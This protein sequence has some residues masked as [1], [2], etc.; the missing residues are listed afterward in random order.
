[1]SRKRRE[2][3]PSQ[4]KEAL[5][6]LTACTGSTV[7]AASVADATGTTCARILDHIGPLVGRRATEA[8]LA[9]SVYLSK[10][11]FPLLERVETGE[12]QDKVVRE[13]AL[14]LRAARP[15]EAMKMA[16]SVLAMFVSI[17]ADFISE[18]LALRLLREACPDPDKEQP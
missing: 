2:P 10:Q 7:D 17:L 12:A 6:L 18:S 15:D 5:R 14:C 16:I 8:L 9:R 11:K 13:L 4:L 1:M 3:G